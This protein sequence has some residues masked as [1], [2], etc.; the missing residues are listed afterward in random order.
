MA[1]ENNLGLALSGIGMFNQSNANQATLNAN[2]ARDKASSMYQYDTQKW[3]ET[4]YGN[5]AKN[6]T[7]KRRF[8]NRA[9]VG[10]LLAKSPSLTIDDF[11]DV[12]QQEGA[13]VFTLKSLRPGAYAKL[14]EDERKR[15][16][17]ILKA[18]RDT[19]LAEARA[20]GNAFGT[21]NRVPSNKEQEPTEESEVDY[22]NATYYIPGMPGGTAMYNQ[23]GTIG[24]MSKIGLMNTPVAQWTNT[25]NGMAFSNGLF[26]PTN[27]LPYIAN[28][29]ARGVYSN[30][31]YKSILG[32]LSGENWK[33]R[34]EVDAVEDSIDVYHT[35]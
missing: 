28:P 1:E 30:T 2:I 24:F 22:T 11:E 5:A 16:D 20:Y 32:L 12:E 4:V 14:G 19:R 26:M 34:K 17:D 7:A 6:L 9:V 35:F 3:G 18:D 10:S 29:S 8:D 27:M 13:N 23:D 25:G 15:V 31:G 21:S 33:K